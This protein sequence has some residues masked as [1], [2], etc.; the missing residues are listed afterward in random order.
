MMC[1]ANSTHGKKINVQ[2]ILIRNTVGKRSLGRS[3][4]RWNVKS[5]IDLK[6][7]G[8]GGGWTRSIWLAI[9]SSERLLW[10]QE[11]HFWVP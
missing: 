10:T 2:R 1:G 11:I 9:V 3:D 8:R 6:E 4:L 5:K 7:I